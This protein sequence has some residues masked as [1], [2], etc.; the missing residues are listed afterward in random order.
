MTTT[1]TTTPRPT[2]D[3]A[4][5]RERLVFACNVFAEPT[6][7]FPEAVT[8]GARAALLPLTDD[9]IRRDLARPVGEASISRVAEWLGLPLAWVLTGD[10]AALVFYARTNRPEGRAAA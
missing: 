3:P 8:A 1:C 2:L 10:L 5:I 9:D 6:V 4:A 7:A